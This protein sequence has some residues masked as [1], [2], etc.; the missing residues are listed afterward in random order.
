MI[1]FNIKKVIRI[2]FHKFLHLFFLYSTILF[3]RQ[4][5]KKEKI[6]KLKNKKKIDNITELINIADTFFTS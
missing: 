4:L 3:S 2:R 1:F 6:V 5:A